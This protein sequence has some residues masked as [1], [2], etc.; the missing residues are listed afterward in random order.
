MTT[1]T[2]TKIEKESVDTWH[3]YSCKCCVHLL[4][5]HIHSIHW[6]VMQKC[7]RFSL[8]FTI[9]IFHQDM[10]SSFICT[11]SRWICISHNNKQSSNVWIWYPHFWTIDNI[12]TSILLG[13]CLQRKCICSRTRFSQAETSNLWLINDEVGM[14]YAT[15]FRFWTLSII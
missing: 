3:E 9:H 10:G 2:N 13:N 14:Q 1:K 12:V 5:N 4:L 8:S 15:S 11:H 6:Y 7:H